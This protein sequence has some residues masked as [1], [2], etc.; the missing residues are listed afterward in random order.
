MPERR[1]T[2]THARD[3][4]A[5]SPLDSLDPP[6]N[7]TIATEERVRA[8]AIG[9]PAYAARKKRIEDLLEHFV[10]AFVAVAEAPSPGFLTDA[11]RDAALLEAARTFDLVAVNR[12][13][14]AHNRYYPIEANLPIEYVTGVFLLRDEPWAPEAS[15]TPASLV[16]AALARVAAQP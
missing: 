12:L 2:G 11:E 8:L 4:A 5:A 3:V 9:V 15:V 7:F 14:D 13:I 16:V 6:R 1:R 10:G